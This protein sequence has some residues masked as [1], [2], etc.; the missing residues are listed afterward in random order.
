MIGNFTKRVLV[1]VVVVVVL[2]L[3]IIYV[4]TFEDLLVI[5][6]CCVGVIIAS[7][8]CRMFLLL[9]FSR[10]HC[11]LLKAIIRTFSKN[12]AAEKAYKLAHS[13]P[14]IHKATC[15]THM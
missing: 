15:N 7:C 10:M 4:H 9:L 2:L 11:L 13:G 5:G 1:G 12:D 3:Q 14:Y 8:C 6:V